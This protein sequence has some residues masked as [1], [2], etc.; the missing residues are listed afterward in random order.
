M[1]NQKKPA[2]WTCRL[3]FWPKNAIIQNELLKLNN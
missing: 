1:N 2:G 3:L